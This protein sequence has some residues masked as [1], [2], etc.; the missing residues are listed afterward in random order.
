MNKRERAA[1]E[2]ARRAAMDAALDAEIE[3][4]ARPLRVAPTDLALFD[5]ALDDSPPARNPAR[6]RRLMTLVATPP[7]DAPLAGVEFGPLVRSA[8]ETAGL[9]LPDV[10]RR[11]HVHRDYLTGL[12]AGARSPHARGPEGARRLV[13]LLA[14]PPRTAALA[15]EN[16]MHAALLPVPTFSARMKRGVPRKERQRI[17]DAATPDEPTAAE[18]DAWR[19]LVDAVESLERSAAR[20]DTAP[21]PA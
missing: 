14:L 10:A 13:S 15:L 20:T 17:L 5:A 19:A 12:E 9:S 4:A 1:A 18:R 8:R 2:A 7:G 11:L 6:A 16:A 3:A 21:S